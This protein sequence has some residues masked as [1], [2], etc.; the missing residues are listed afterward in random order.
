MFCREC[1]AM[2]PRYGGGHVCRICEDTVHPEDEC[3][4]S[5]DEIDKYCTTTYEAWMDA[6]SEVHRT[7]E[8][9]LILGWVYGTKK[10]EE[11]KGDKSTCGI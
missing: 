4:M 6:Q 2:S 3:C 1:K 11:Q 10:K 9:R 7:N 8:L 5:I